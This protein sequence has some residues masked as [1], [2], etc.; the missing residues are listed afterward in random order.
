[1]IK[2]IL[3]LIIIGVFILINCGGGETAKPDDVVLGNKSELKLS[4]EER[5]SLKYSLEVQNTL[6][7]VAKRVVPGVVNIRA[8]R[9]VKNKANQYL[10]DPLYKFFF[11]DK[12]KNEKKFQKEQILGSGFII[13]DKGHIVTNYHVVTGFTNIS[14][15]LY[16]K[17]EF[18][19]KVIGMD[20]KTD[21]ALLKITS[22][23]NL[24]VLHLGESSRLRVGDFAIA[25]GN[26]FGLVG[27]FTLG[28]IS[29]IGRSDIDINAPFKNYIQTDAS[30]NQGNSGGPLINILGEVIGM[31]SAIYSTTGGSIGIGFAIPVDVIKVVVKD[32]IEKGRVDRGYLG[33]TIQNITK[34]IAKD[35]KIPVRYGV[36]VHSVENGS[37]ASYSGIKPGDVIYQVEGRK[38]R[39]STDL[40]RMIAS[41]KGGKKIEISI[42]RKGKKKTLNLVLKNRPKRK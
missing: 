13:S 42:F 26:P 29:A 9:I 35:L 19:A 20:E 8:E 2:R 24:P 4:D 28:V 39:N 30:V 23:G 16:D 34:E 27:T 38:V 37:P 3:T 15:V 36:L 11:G 6:R 7:N 10:N 18:K 40:V 1:M 31:N 22:D 14:V 41:Y 17:R 32:L 25:V 5:K 12:F 21:I 33:V